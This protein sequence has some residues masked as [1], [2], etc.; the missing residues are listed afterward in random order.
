MALCSVLRGRR[1]SKSENV[2]VASRQRSQDTQRST[3]QA[4]SADEPLPQ[5]WIHHPTTAAG[6]ATEPTVLGQFQS[7]TPLVSGGRPGS[8]GSQSAQPCRHTPHPA[9]QTHQRQDQACYRPVGYEC[10]YSGRDWH[11]V[12]ESYPWTSEQGRD[13]RI[14]CRPRNSR[15]CTEATWPMGLSRFYTFDQATTSPFRMRNPFSLAMWHNGKSQSD[16]SWNESGNFQ[17]PDRPGNGSWRSREL[18]GN[19]RGIGMDDMYRETRRV[20]ICP[21]LPTLSL[22]WETTLVA[23]RTPGTQLFFFS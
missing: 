14:G 3:L 8:Q 19:L 9:N 16:G 11:G 7:D 10:R 15:T 2:P 1:A 23:T 6:A 4:S 21:P 17:P 12:C 22:S 13:S 5:L 18:L 20:H